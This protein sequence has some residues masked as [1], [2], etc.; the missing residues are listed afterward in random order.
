MNLYL[1][2][3]VWILNFAI[4]LWNAYACGSV[5]AETKTAGG[6]RHL[7]T[8]MGAIMSASGFTWCYLIVLV[9]GAHEFKWLDNRA[10]TV[11]LELGYV[12]IIPG[13]LFSGMMITIDSWATAYRQGGVLNYGMAAYNTY[14]QVHNTLNAIDGLGPAIADIFS[15]FTSDRKSSS[16]DS[17]SD[18]SDSGVAV[19]LVIV[20]VALAVAGGILTTAAII[21]RVAAN[22]PRWTLQEMEMHRMASGAEPVTPEGMRAQSEHGQTVRSEQNRYR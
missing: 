8:W 7:M 13:V 22:R 20:L 14:A 4:S 21:K 16:S 1:L 6:W 9:M 19:L 2:L 3:F 10:C 18:D 5:W 17:S 11:A 15:F 12:L